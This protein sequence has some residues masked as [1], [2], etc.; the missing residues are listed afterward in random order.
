MAQQQSQEGGIPK[1][2]N[3]RRYHEIKQELYLQLAD[4]DRR[5][6]ETK[7]AEKNEASKLSPETSEIFK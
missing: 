4:E 3:L 5:A 6:Y 2:V 1:E 7:A